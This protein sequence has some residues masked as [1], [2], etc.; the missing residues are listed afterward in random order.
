MVHLG[1][2]Q[3]FV[4]LLFFVVQA[5]ILRA[6]SGTRFRLLCSLSVFVPVAFGNLFF[7]LSDSESATLLFLISTT[8]FL[9]Y[10]TFFLLKDV[11]TTNLVDTS[12]LLNAVSAYLLIAIIAAMVHGLIAFF[13]PNSYNF[14]EVADTRSDIYE[15]MYFSVVTLTTLG[16]GDYLPLSEVAKSF[17]AIEALVGQIYIAVIIARLVSLHDTKP[18]GEP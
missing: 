2:P 11:F 1:A 17:V 14:M 12:T 18:Q 10:A 3:V 8:V 9:A 6:F 13:I 5:I 7:I 4:S 15:L 16:Y